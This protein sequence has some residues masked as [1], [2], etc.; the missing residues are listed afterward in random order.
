MAHVEA[1]L[2]TADEQATIDRIVARFHQVAKEEG[3]DALTLVNS[4]MIIVAKGVLAGLDLRAVIQS[5]VSTVMANQSPAEAIATVARATPPD[6][7][8]P[9]KPAPRAPVPRP[10]LRVG[11]G[12]N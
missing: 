1:T 12:E 4:A 5:L 7:G 3:I 11:K 2:A 10:P 6:G 8:P 9:V